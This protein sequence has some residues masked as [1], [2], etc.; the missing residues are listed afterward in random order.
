MKG[1]VL[2]GGL[3]TRLHPLTK[4]TNKHLLPVYDKP[5]IHYPLETLI[6]SGIK[7]ILL[8]TGPEHAGDFTNL[9]KSGEEIGA[10]LTYKVQ[11]KPDGIAGALRLAEDFT[12]GG[13]I[14]VILG[15]NIYEDRF[16]LTEFESGA[17]VFLKV[18]P[19][20]KRYGVAE[21]KDGKVVD[22]Q[23]KPENPKTN[24][25][26][27]GLYQ[28]DQR[29]FEL[30]NTLKPSGRGELEISDLNNEYI[31]LGELEYDLLRGYWTDAG[32]IESL[33]RANMLV[34]KFREE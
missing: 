13:P 14:T 9:L 5:M 16:D 10:N 17:K 2:A 34:E 33:H 22:I 3:G 20:P 32:T 7:D 29:A 6:K 28:Y 4:V 19:E 21:L 12:S 1:V 23:E 18:V 26:V 11:D 31:R 27:T 8:V 24:Y 30:I 15:D 25:A